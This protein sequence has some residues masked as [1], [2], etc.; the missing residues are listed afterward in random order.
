M[1]K[2][3][4]RTEKIGWLEKGDGS[5]DPEVGAVGDALFRNNG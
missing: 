2:G 1:L 5:F 3:G 4:C